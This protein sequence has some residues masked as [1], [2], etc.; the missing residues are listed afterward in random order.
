MTAPY[1]CTSSRRRRR[2]D[3]RAGPDRLYPVTRGCGGLGFGSGLVVEVPFEAPGLPA[4]GFDGWP[5]FDGS[6]GFTGWVSDGSPGDGFSS[7]WE[8]TAG[9]SCTTTLSCG[10]PQ[11]VEAPALFASPEYTATQRY[12]PAVVG[13]AAETRRCRC[14]APAAPQRT[15]P[16]R[17][18]AG[19]RAV[20]L[21]RDRAPAGRRRPRAVRCRRRR[22]RCERCRWGPPW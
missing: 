19:R 4:V 6:P 14:R 1:A 20:Q 7:G 13:A 9:G 2:P 22:R 12:V 16:A 10:S 18:T 8:G 17:C 5:G 3:R 15:P 21:E 11:R